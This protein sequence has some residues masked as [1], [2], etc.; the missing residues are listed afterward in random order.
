MQEGYVPPSSPRVNSYDRQSAHN[1]RPSDQDVVLPS[2]ERET[3]DLTS[4]PRR[5]VAPQR[6]KENHNAHYRSY[7]QVQ[8]PKRKAFPS[9]A[10]DIGSHAGEHTKRLRPVYREEAQARSHASAYHPNQATNSGSRPRVP[11]PQQVIDLTATPH[12][13][14]TSGGNGYY[15]PAHSLAEPSGHVYAAVPS[16][17]S[18]VREV[19]GGYYEAPADGTSQ[20]YIPD[21]KLYERRAP[22]ARDY[23]P[24]R[25]ARQPPRVAEESARYLRSGV[26]YGG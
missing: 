1:R 14:P 21:T 17:P 25:E 16:R 23:I 15:A 12:R 2:V 11:P 13:H 26:R 7:D 18:P 9:Y 4:S 24:L 8:S 6:Q 10:D 5:V 20:S 3:V 22:P 19:R